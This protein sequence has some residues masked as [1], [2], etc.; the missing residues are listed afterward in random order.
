M[1]LGNA[2]L[3]VGVHLKADSNLDGA[4]KRDAQALRQLGVEGR[5]AGEQTRRGMDAATASMRRSEAIARRLGHAIGTAIV[6][7]GWRAALQATIRQEAATA[8]LEQRLK[9]TGGAAGLTSQQLQDLASNMQRLTTFGDEAVLEMEHLLLQFTNIR[10]PIFRQAVVAVLDMSTAMGQ[11]LKSS[12]LQLG[13]ALNDP[14]HNIQGLNQ[15]T[16]QFTAAETRKIEQLSGANRLLEAQTLILN[17]V[18]GAM[19]GAAEAAGKT[20]G[21]AL[22]KLK[23][24]FGDLF[25]QKEG[26]NEAA[27]AV[28][29]LTATLSDPA[30]AAGLRAL[31]ANAAS[32]AGY[33]A[34]AA[35]SFGSFLDKVG[36][37]FEYGQQRTDAQIAERI[38][39]LTQKRA[40]S[41]EKINALEAQI[42][43]WYPARLFASEKELAAEKE[44]LATITKA[45][46][47]VNQ[48]ALEQGQVEQP[49]APG[50][51]GAPG[52]A[53]PPLDYDPYGPK[54]AQQRAKNALESLKAINEA[55]LSELDR[56]RELDLVGVEDYW[57]RRLIIEQSNIDKEIAV[58]RGELGVADPIE[59]QRILGEISVLETKRVAL[60]KNADDQILI[61]R[62]E[63]NDQ[64]ISLQTRLLATQGDQLQASIIDL[65]HEFQRT[66]KQLK[67]T[68]DEEGVALAQKLFNTEVAKAQL[69]ELVR[70]FDRAIQKMNGSESQ[71]TRE[72]DLQVIT[73]SDKRR[74][75]LQLYK[76]TAAEVQNLIPLMEKLASSLG[77]D[78]VAQ[79][80]ALRLEFEQLQKPVDQTV[81]ELSGSLK[82]AFVD[83]LASIGHEAKT[84]KQALLDLV[85]SILSV[86][87]RR[88]AQQLVD[89]LF[90]WAPVS[91]TVTAV[92]AVLHEGGIVGQGGRSRIV[93][94]ALF[95]GAPRYHSGALVGNERPAILQTGEEVLSRSDPRNRANGGGGGGAALRII[96]VMDP[97]LVRDY[98]SSADGAR[99]ILNVLQNNAGAV[100]QTVVGGA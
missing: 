89:S 32:L 13:R 70:E 66:I 36:K 22:E 77:P 29:R 25:E 15:A 49:A 71:I 35:S 41:L 10:G 39:S 61:Y 56:Q 96:N 100:R 50:A 30:T 84:A 23:N 99:V 97:G 62:R 73:E 37:G 38:Q 20:F 60:A 93:D 55:A 76:D 86:I 74:E 11:D 69:D 83:A 17:K 7:L 45:L 9:S 28:N 40:E 51:P 43:G 59:Q 46:V 4:A 52:A 21:G 12:A 78:A 94:P 1:A 95:I 8:Q 48:L 33:A 31:V 42:N 85:A 3:N 18:K 81:K 14:I 44:R 68:G 80:R 26:L 90:T 57:R 16:I 5:K 65:A 54:L 2:D 34:Q 58:K 47:A 88:L 72:A 75:I 87:Q 82:S 24:A 91:S 27:A 64:L 63:L 98:M 67:L 53:A 92:A 79:V 6:G 19:D